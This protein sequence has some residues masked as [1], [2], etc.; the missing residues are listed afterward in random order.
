MKLEPLYNTLI[1]SGEL[2]EE[3]W[4]DWLWRTDPEEKY[5]P[6]VLM[7]RCQ[8]LGLLICLWK[9]MQP[10]DAASSDHGRFTLMK[11]PVK[12]MSLRELKDTIANFQ[13]EWPSF[14]DRLP[15]T[16]NPQSCLE[17]VIALVDQCMTRFGVL[18]LHA[19][20][21]AV[22]DDLSSVEEIKGCLRITLSCIRRT[23]C[24][25]LVIYRHLHL[26]SVAK[27]VPS[28][29]HDL[30]ITKYHVEASSDDFNIMCMHLSLPVAA[31][32]NY[33]HD[34][35]EM[36]NHVSQVVFFHNTEYQRIPRVSLEKLP[37]ADPQHVL[38]AIMQLYPQIAVHYEEDHIDL[39]TDGDWMWL[40]VAGRIYLLDP[41]R[42]VYYSPSVTSLVENIYL[43]Q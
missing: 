17:A 21:Q 40:V 13:I 5:T 32:L 39:F 8:L 12:S 36:Y 35:P 4:D 27:Q 30:G 11:T 16:P 28:G 37:E 10:S 14:L 43:K 1:Q 34:F 38:P 22:L 2:P 9:A 41:K 23:V 33:K 18:C 19:G 15:S 24:T 6:K 42:N 20:D 25:F 3:T 26:L 7:N 29:W 31:K